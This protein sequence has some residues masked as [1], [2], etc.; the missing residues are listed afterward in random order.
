MEIKKDIMP[1]VGI[2]MSLLTLVSTVVVISQPLDL[3]LENRVCIVMSLCI[4][5]G[6][7]IGIT[8]RYA[9]CDY[10]EYVIEDNIS[11]DETSKGEVQQGDTQNEEPLLTTQCNKKG[12]QF[13]DAV[14]VRTITPNR[15][16]STSA[17]VGGENDIGDLRIEDEVIEL[18]INDEEPKVNTVIQQPKLVKCLLLHYY[19]ALK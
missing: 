3:S 13:R 6:L 9:D 5:S 10:G 7:S 16:T 12:V 14:E 18:D 8:A 17:G 2:T 19:E 11:N 1:M 4:L 15:S